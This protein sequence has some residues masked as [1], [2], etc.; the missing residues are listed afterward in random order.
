[1]GFPAING[2]GRKWRRDKE[3]YNREGWGGD[4]SYYKMIKEIV[5]PPNPCQKKFSTALN[6]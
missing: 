4:N 6:Y 3:R 5:D 1:M 2:N